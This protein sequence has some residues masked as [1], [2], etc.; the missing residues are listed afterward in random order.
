MVILASRVCLSHHNKLDNV[1]VGVVSSSI[2]SMLEITCT[3]CKLHNMVAGNLALKGKYLRNVKKRVLPSGIQV[4]FSMKAGAE[5][6]LLCGCVVLCVWKWVIR[7]CKFIEEHLYWVLTYQREKI[8]LFCSVTG[9]KRLK[10]FKSFIFLSFFLIFATGDLVTSDEMATKAN[11]NPDTIGG[12]GKKDVG[13]GALTAY[14]HFKEGRSFAVASPQT[15]A[16]WHLS[17]RSKRRQRKWT[18]SRMSM[19]SEQTAVRLLR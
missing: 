7:K 18:R 5:V 17:L 9:K 12:G 3:K 13:E 19:C 6:E 4:H 10:W 14:M 1:F 16:E 8:Y 15:W 11:F 2:P